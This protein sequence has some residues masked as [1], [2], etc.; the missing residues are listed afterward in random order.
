MNTAKLPRSDLQ[1]KS[2]HLLSPEKT[3]ITSLFPLRI[4]KS[5]GDC[6]TYTTKQRPASTLPTPQLENRSTDLP[7]LLFPISQNVLRNQHKNCSKERLR[8]LCTGTRRRSR[9]RFSS[10]CI[11]AFHVGIPPRGLGGRLRRRCGLL[12]VLVMQQ[13]VHDSDG[14]GRTRKMRWEHRDIVKKDPPSLDGQSTKTS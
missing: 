4:S 9:S 13:N 10:L 12:D 3:Y 6:S 14:L 1:A 8:W 11:T 2:K 7:Q 5:S